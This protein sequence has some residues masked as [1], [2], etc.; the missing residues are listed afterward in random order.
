[1]K[2]CCKN[3]GNEIKYNFNPL[4]NSASIKCNKCKKKYRLDDINYNKKMYYIITI[5]L[6]CVLIV[7]CLDY[8]SI[9]DFIIKFIVCVEFAD[10]VQYFF[11]V[12]SIKKYGFK[13]KIKGQGKD[14]ENE[15]LP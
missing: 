3:C 9:I 4:K 8:K 11:T 12:Y 7:I 5:P 6:M 10:I 2:I 13:E 14:N 1:M 15:I